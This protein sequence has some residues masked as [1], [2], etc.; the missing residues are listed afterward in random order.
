MKRKYTHIK[1]L[2]GTILQLRAEG[3]TR[4]E[5][6]EEFGLSIQQIKNLIN[7]RNRREGKLALGNEPKKRGRPRILPVTTQK[8]LELEN[9][10]LRMEVELLRSFLQAAGRR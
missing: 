7:R 9:K 5:I 3:K 2:E 8:E 1:C 6:A 10:Q 4:R